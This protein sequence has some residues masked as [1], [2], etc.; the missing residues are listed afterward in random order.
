MS[1][2]STVVAEEV[3]GDASSRRGGAGAADEPASAPSYR[4]NCEFCSAVNAGLQ[5]APEELPAALA[6][7][8]ASI[9]DA[10]P[11]RHAAI[12]GVDYL[13]V[14]PAA[15]SAPAAGGGGGGAVAAE[16]DDT[17]SIVFVNDTSGSMCITEAV[18]DAIARRL[19]GVESR[20]ANLARLKASGDDANQFLPGEQRGVTYVSR[21]QALQAAIS[22]QVESLAR[23]KPTVRVGLV[24]FAADVTV[25]GDGAAPPR[26]LA[27]SRLADYDMLKAV[28]DGTEL[29]RPVSECVASLTKSIYEWQ[30]DGSTALGPA[31]LV[32][33]AM[34]ARKRGSRVVV[35]TDGLANTGLGSLELPDAA[36]GPPSNARDEAIAR[37]KADTD[38]FY[39]RLRALAVDAGVTVDVVGFEGAD[40]NLEALG[41]LSE[42]TSGSVTR[43]SPA[44]ITEQFAGVLEDDIVALSASVT[45]I[46]H[47]AITIRDPAQDAA[48]ESEAMAV[49]ASPAVMRSK[50]KTSSPAPAAL[51]DDS[52]DDSV[53]A[54]AI[55]GPEA[56]RSH[57][58]E[59]A[60]ERVLQQCASSLSASKPY[61]VGEAAH[62]AVT[63][64]VAKPPVGVGGG[65]GKPPLQ[66]KA[67]VDSAPSVPSSVTAG[68]NTIAGLLAKKTGIGIRAGTVALESP[69]PAPAD[70]PLL[71]AAL[72]SAAPTAAAGPD[73]PSTTAPAL[74][75]SGGGGAFAAGSAVAAPMA[76][77][78]TIYIGNVGKSSQTT[79]EYS[80]K[81]RVDMPPALVSQLAGLSTLPFQLQI[82][83]TKKDGSQLLRVITYAQPVTRE[84]A[85]AHATM[86]ASPMVSHA[87]RSAAAYAK[88]G[89]YHESNAVSTVAQSF[90]SANLRS[91]DA[92]GSAVFASYSRDADRLQTVLKSEITKGWAKKKAAMPS[93]SRGAPPDTAAATRSR[94]SADAEV[95]PGAP[96]RAARDAPADKEASRG[97]FSRMTSAAAGA[98]SSL[99]SP[100]SKSVS[101]PATVFSAPIGGAAA[102]GPGGERG[103]GG[104][105]AYESSDEEAEGVKAEDDADE[106]SSRIA[107][108]AEND[109]LAVQIFQLSR[110]AAKYT[111]R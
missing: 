7:N 23:S 60:R 35:C 8:V 108:R 1:G 9:T 27:G 86:L 48:M 93:L 53:L 52:S 3:P 57:L 58:R 2:I 29:T 64:A 69:A 96:A 77:A 15:D 16:A 99:L 84:A 79:F 90:V 50:M 98:V 51:D 54:S 61:R 94:R 92:E 40:C 45:M 70:L 63:D 111:P 72:A 89:R 83:Y 25:Y 73:A 28:G 67:A 91:E 17:T 107:A 22:A 65:G 12:R 39:A 88:A 102:G 87:A 21:L 66:R 37:A 78:V 110:G 103:G 62:K 43:V 75:G 38:A 106:A 97:F 104:G 32:G 30:E 13:L 76:T 18:A 109:E 42:A 71:G 44:N 33:I 4:W 5:L 20:A 14:P 24:T 59:A 80:Q 100:S 26:V 81:R 55:K 95:A 10:S 68:V 49:E 105:G 6:A 34:A 101:A 11:S 47:A 46:S 85:V 19:R 31:L 41:G 56:L 74:G 82:A 36:R